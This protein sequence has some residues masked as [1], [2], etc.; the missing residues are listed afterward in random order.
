MSVFSTLFAHAGSNHDERNKPLT[1][2][3]IFLP[4]LRTFRNLLFVLALLFWSDVAEDG[5]VCWPTPLGYD[6]VEI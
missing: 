1:V 5:S 4:S 6:G 3:R 2:F